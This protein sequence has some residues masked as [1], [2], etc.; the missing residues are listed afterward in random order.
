MRMLPN[1]DPVHK[2]SIISRGMALGYTMP[3]PAEDR[4]LMSRA[5]FMDDLAGLMGG[6]VAEKLVFGDMTTGSGN[7]LERA[8]DIARRMVTEWGMSDT[9][10]PRTFGKREELVFLGREI[11]EQR[12]YSEEVAGPSTR[13]CARSSSRQ[14]N[15]AQHI[16]TQY[17]HVLD[18]VAHRLIK[19]ETLDAAA[20]EA[21][22]G[23]IKRPEV[24]MPVVRLRPLPLPHQRRL[25]Q[26]DANMECDVS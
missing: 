3:L 21:L 6:H 17:R 20:F 25:L 26:A 2:I 13:K 24:K 23:D 18:A 7:D 5:K 19:D 4:H 11:T 12:N 8:T 14:P 1:C 10:G 22:F 15:A 16:L 9:L